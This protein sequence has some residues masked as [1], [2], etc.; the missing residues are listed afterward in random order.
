MACGQTLDV[1]D[2]VFT[3]LTTRT[4]DQLRH[5]RE[6][7]ARV[8]I[9]EEQAWKSRSAKLWADEERRRAEFVSAREKRERQERLMIGLAIALVAVAMAVVIIVAVSTRTS[10]PIPLF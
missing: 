4:S 10:T 6:T 1:I 3:R 7:G 5:V 2:T 8:K 9:N